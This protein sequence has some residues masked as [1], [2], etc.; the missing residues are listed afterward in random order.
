MKIYS[1][2]IIVIALMYAFIY[3]A[4]AHA[5]TNPPFT[6]TVTSKATPSTGA[7]DFKRAITAEK[8]RLSELKQ[9]ISPTR[10]ITQTLKRGSSGE[11]V[12]LLQ[13]FLKLYGTFSGPTTTGYFGTQ[14]AKAVKEFQRK[15]TLEQLGL[16]GPKTRARIFALSNRELS[17]KKVQIASSSP[18]TTPMITDVVFSTDVGEDGSGVGSSTVF[19]SNT[20]NIYAILTI[21]NAEQNTMLGIIRYHNGTYIDSAVTHPS[22]TGLRYSHF[23]WALKDGKNR[24]KGTYLYNFYINGK[25]SKTATITIN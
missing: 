4:P 5:I 23:Q 16:V 2:K 19:A 20:K 1:K 10:G 11:D 14:T 13:Q 12:L 18:K 6:A 22:R 8:I 17:K 3:A 24:T 25:K 9:K 15:E 7:V 21:T